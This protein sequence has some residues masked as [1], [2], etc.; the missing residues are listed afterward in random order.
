MGVLAVSGQSADPTL[1]AEPHT[2]PALARVVVPAPAPPPAPERPRLIS[3]ALASALAA[4]MPAYDPPSAHPVP[5]G[6]AASG[7]TGGPAAPKN[8]ILRLPDYVVHDRKIREFSERE[9]S[10]PK[11]LRE[12][13]VKRYITELD[14]ALNAFQIPLFSGYSTAEDRGNAPEKRAMRAY[15]EQEARDRAAEKS[16]LE[17]LDRMH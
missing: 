17:A 4:A 13:A 11:G 7:A 3:P 1:I 16:D 8:G 6:S 15:D 12:I 9:I 10:T 5:A 14:A 2:P